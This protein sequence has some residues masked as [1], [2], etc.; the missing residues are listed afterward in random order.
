VWSFL[1]GALHASCEVGTFRVKV[2]GLAVLD[3]AVNV[4]A[5]EVNR[6]RYAAAH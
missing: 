3:Q 4:I 1:D 2:P 6:R 5:F